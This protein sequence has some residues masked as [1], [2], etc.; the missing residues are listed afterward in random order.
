MGHKL[1]VNVQKFIYE[2]SNEINIYES[3]SWTGNWPRILSGLLVHID[4]EIHYSILVD[5][6]AHLGELDNFRCITILDHFMYHISNRNMTH[7][8]GGFY[9]YSRCGTQNNL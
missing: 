2:K 3:N 7:C 6:C 5:V 4:W 9:L 8:I 1:H